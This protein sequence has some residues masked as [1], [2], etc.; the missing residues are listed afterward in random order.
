MMRGSPSACIS[1]C[2][3]G[4]CLQESAELFFDHI[5]AAAAVALDVERHDRVMHGQAQQE[6][7]VSVLLIERDAHALAVVVGEL[8]AR[9]LGG[10]VGEVGD[11]ALAARAEILFQDL[12]PH[13][14]AF[15]RLL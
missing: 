2:Q 8:P 13:L 4:R 11:D 7:A 3:P 14:A 6:P 9:L 15:Q 1:Q 12:E 5:H 10:L